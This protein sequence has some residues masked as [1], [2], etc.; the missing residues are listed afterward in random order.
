M[1]KER[2]FLYVAASFYLLFAILYM[3]F[4]LA[5]TEP[6]GVTTAD[7]TG[8]IDIRAVYGGF[9]LGLAIFLFWSA[10]EDERIY[11]GLLITILTTGGIALV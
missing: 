4:P 10:G 7:S 11:P 3:L 5:L 8:V 2:I 9:Q 6:M 1:A